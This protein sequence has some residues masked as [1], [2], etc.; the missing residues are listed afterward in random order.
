[1]DGS[2]QSPEMVMHQVKAE[3][4]NAYAQEFFTTTRDRCFKLCVTKPSGSMSSSEQACLAKCT[5]R[6]VEATKMISQ[7]VL[8]AYSKGGM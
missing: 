3:L 4:A 5:E 1:M 8:Q 6:Y 2:Q 7:V